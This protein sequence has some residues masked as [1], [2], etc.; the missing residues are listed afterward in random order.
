MS[1]RTFIAA[2]LAFATCIASGPMY[3]Q[4][5]HNS[6]TLLGL[7]YED[8]QKLIPRNGRMINV[9]G[10]FFRGDAFESGRFSEVRQA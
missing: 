6:E 8:A 9:G 3:A 4:E 7:N 2:A 1:G 10:G 5:G